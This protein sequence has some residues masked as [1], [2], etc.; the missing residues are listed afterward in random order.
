MLRNGSSDKFSWQPEA[1]YSPVAE[2]L[3]VRLLFSA[4]AARGHEVLQADFPIYV[5]LVELVRCGA[6]P[7]E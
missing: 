6:R 5:R 3:T 1:T 7:G 2:L 4:A